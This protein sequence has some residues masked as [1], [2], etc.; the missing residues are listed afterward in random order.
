MTLAGAESPTR[1]GTTS[2]HSGAGFAHRVRVGMSERGIDRVLIALSR[3][4][5]AL[6]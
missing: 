5:V 2:A 6:P 4:T 1:E 3:H